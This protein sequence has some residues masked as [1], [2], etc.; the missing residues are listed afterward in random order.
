MPTADTN[1]DYERRLTDEVWNRST[2]YYEVAR[3][4]TLATYRDNEV[5][6]MGLAALA[7]GESVLDV[8]C[9]EGTTLD[10]ARPR[11]GVGCDLSRTALAMARREYPRLVLVNCSGNALPFRTG[12]FPAVSSFFAIEHFAAP[13]QVLAELVRVVASNGLLVICGPNYGSPINRNPYWREH[14]Y[15][16]FLRRLL[17]CV[18]LL[19]HD[20]STLAWEE[21]TPEFL[22]RGEVV[23]ECDI[24]TNPYLGTLI[25]F[26]EVRGMQRERYTAGWSWDRGR[27]PLRQKLLRMLAACRVP[28]FVYCGPVFCLVMRKGRA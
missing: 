1:I 25:R 13:E 7:G 16:F 22:S 4:G 15:K 24:L 5:Y 28:P 18:Q 8:G 20:G 21:N 26:L 17:R 2:T 9:G 23:P 10:L 19:G 27:E 11:L 14:R 3:D 6:R 12:A